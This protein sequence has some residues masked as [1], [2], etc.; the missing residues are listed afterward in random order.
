MTE[1]QSATP[2]FKYSGPGYYRTANGKRA[3]VGQVSEGVLRSLSGIVYEKDNIN[4]EEVIR[5]WAENGSCYVNSS[6]DLVDVWVEPVVIEGFLNIYPS[7]KE[8]YYVVF[9]K[10]KEEADKGDVAYS[11]PRLSCVYFK[12]VE[13]KF[14]D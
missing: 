7:S 4:V 8:G 14:D 1:E 2:Q 9:Y 13:G 11:A 6:Y 3:L 12:T 5:T 10:N